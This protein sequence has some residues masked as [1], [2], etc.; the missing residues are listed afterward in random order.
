[1]NNNTNGK[2]TLQL[3]EEIHLK[4]CQTSKMEFSLGSS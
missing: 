3:N 1:M 2:A 4:K